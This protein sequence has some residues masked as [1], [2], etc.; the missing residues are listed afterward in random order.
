MESKENK[1]YQP[2]LGK[3]NN[4]RIYFYAV[5]TTCMFN[6]TKKPMKSEQ[7]GKYL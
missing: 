4:N 5:T 3:C 7:T 6:F 2:Y 1:N